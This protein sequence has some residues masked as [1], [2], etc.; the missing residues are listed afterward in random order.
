MTHNSAP[1]P[2]QRTMIAAMIIFAA[3]FSV[4]GIGHRW[5]AM[6]AAGHTPMV[7]G[8]IQG[9]FVVV[10]VVVA[11]VPVLGQHRP[12]AE[13]TTAGERGESDYGTGR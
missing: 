12:H 4:H 5:R 9:I 1:L 8:M 2:A 6:T 10:A 11:V 7:G 3:L 13:S